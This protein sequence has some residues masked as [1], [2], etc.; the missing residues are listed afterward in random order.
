M[1][2]VQL[3]TAAA[4]VIAGA[5]IGAAVPANAHGTAGVT[6]GTGGYY[7]AYCDPYSAYYN[8]YYCNGG[9]YGRSHGGVVV[10]RSWH[11]GHGRVIVDRFRGHQGSWNHRSSGHGSWGHRSGGSHGNRGHGGHRGH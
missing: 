11:G 1:K 7:S 10:G 2:Y 3:K 8:P 6:I 4:L 9:Y 5:M